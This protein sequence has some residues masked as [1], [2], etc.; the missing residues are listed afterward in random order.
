MNVR[1]ATPADEQTLLDLTAAIFAE[2]WNRPWPA[3][4]I[5]P[6]LWEGSLVL[7]AEDD[8]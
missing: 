4:E 7:L 5:T 6:A 3:P 2:N 8:G 1:E